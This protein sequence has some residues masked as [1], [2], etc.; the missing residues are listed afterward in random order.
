MSEDFF[1]EE[2]S[3]S[4]NPQD[5]FLKHLAKDKAWYIGKDVIDLSYIILDPETIQ[6]GIGRFAKGYEFK[7]AEHKGGKRV[8][9]DDTWKDAFSV[10]VFVHGHDKPVLWERMSWGEVQAFRDICPSFWHGANKE[11]PALPVFKY[12]GSKTVS[13]ESGFISS[14]P[15][16]EFQGY[17]PRP[18]GFVIPEWAN[19]DPPVAKEIEEQAKSQEAKAELKQDD[20]PF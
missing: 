6:T 2:A 7:W 16:F 4:D 8:K 18:E 12:I 1:T 19:D 15:E 14:V 9:P 13:H 5:L 11:A 3:S 10:W 17:K 20:I